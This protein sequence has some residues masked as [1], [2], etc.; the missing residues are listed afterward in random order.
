M[1]RLLFLVAAALALWVS[2]GTAQVIQ[3]DQSA[4]LYSTNYQ[5]GVNYRSIRGVPISN[6]ANV[7]PGSDGRE[8]IPNSA[9]TNQFQGFV[10]YGAVVRPVTSTNLVGTSSFAQNASNIG[11]PRATNS[12]G[13]VLIVLRSAQVGAQYFSRQV[14]FFY[15]AVIPPPT[16][17]VDGN[18]LA[19]AKPEDYWVAEPYTTNGHTNAPYYWS[20]HAGAV[21]AVQPGPI[22]VSWKKAQPS[23]TVPS[24]YPNTNRYYFDS[25]LY[26]TFSNATYIV[27]GS[28]VKPPRK[29]YWTEGVFRATGKPVAVPTARVGA[30]QIVYNT[31][32]FPQRVTNEFVATGQS[33]VVDNVTNRV[34]E[35]RTLWYDTQQ[36]QIYAYNREGR[37]FLEL[38]GDSLGGNVRRHLGY[39]I[40]DVYQ[41]PTPL[42]IVAEL[43]ELI[44]P[45]VDGTPDD[46]LN[47]EL[48]LVGAAQSFLYSHPIQGSDR[49]DRYAAE[50]TVNLNDVLVHWTEAGIEGLRWPSIYGRYKLVWPANIAKYSHYVRP[51]VSTE[52]EARLT[53]VPLPAENVPAIQ[54]QDALDQP[55]AKLT[56]S[57]KFYTFLATN[58][59][60]HRTLLRLTAG[61]NVAFERVFSW[62]DVNL[63][64]TNFNRTLATNLTAVSDFY[65]TGV[66]YP[67]TPAYL[68]GR[69]RGVNGDW[70]LY[71]RDTAGT[72]SGSIVSWAMQVVTTNADSGTL[73][74][75]EVQN[76]SGI[77]I[78]DNANANPYPSPLTITG[79]TDAVV[80]IRVKLNGVTHT[81]PKDIDILLVS[82]AGKVCSIMSAAGGGNPG[83]I[84]VNLILDDAASTLLP[85]TQITSGTFKPTHY[86]ADEA[87]PPGATGSI[88]TS[89]AALLEAVPAPPTPTPWPSGPTAPG[90]VNRIA[91]VGERIEASGIGEQPLAGYILQSKGTSFHP[92]AYK[93]PFVSGF[94][95][96]GR[97]AIIPVNAIPGANNLDIWWFRVNSTDEVKN[98]ANGF[99]PI[100]WPEV[101][102][103]YTLAWPA[104]P[105]E[106]V[107]AS[108]DGSGAMDSLLQRGTIY[109]Q[110]DPT[111]PGFNPNEEH[112]IMLGGTAY[113][114]RDDLNLTG[115][116]VPAVLSG[117][118]A[119]YSSDPFVLLD[120]TGAD[121]RPALQAFKVLREKPS[122][123]IVFDYI[124]EAGKQLQP[125]MPLSFLP[126]PVDGVGANAVN[127]NTEPSG[128]AGDLPVGWTPVQD[129]GSYANYK[130]FT[131]KDR[132]DSF[133]VMRGP[134]A[135]LPALQ[136]GTYSVVSNAFFT[137]L[138]AATAVVG[139]PFTNVFHTSRRTESLVLSL[140]SPTALPEGLQIIGVRLV[141]VPNSAG[142]NFYTFTLTDDGVSVTN[143]LSLNIKTNGSV[144]AQGPLTIT[145]YNKYAFNNAVYVD[146][147]PVLAAPAETN[148]CFTM[149]F[150]YKTQRGFAWP[151]LQNSP[152]EGSIV[153]YL[154]PVGSAA[155]PAASSTP[156]LDIV[157]RPVWPSITPTMMFGQSLTGTAD[158][159]L[160][161][162][163]GQTSVQV[164]YQQSIAKDI[165][166]AKPAVVLHDPTAP[167]YFA[168]KDNSSAGLAQIPDGV[169]QEVYQGKTYF[170]NLPPHL[171]QRFYFDPDRGAKGSLVFKGEYKDEVLGEKY[172]LLNVLRGSSLARGDDLA[173]VLNLC[174][175]APAD[176]KA[177]WDAAITNGMVATVLTKY[178][179]PAVPGQ[180][181]DDP[182]LTRTVGIGNLI[183]V[184]DSQTAVDSYA[185]TA[186]GPGQ[187]YVT[188]ITANSGNP[189]QT[190]TGDKVSVFVVKV[191][192]KLFP[193]EIKIVPSANPLSEVSSFQHTPDLAGRFDEYEYEWKINPPVDG[194]PPVT[195]ATM[196]R[197][198]PLITGLGLPRYTLGGSGIQALVDNY[199]VLRYR[200]KNTSHPLYNQW[201]E[202]T[203]PPTLAE[204]WIKR[205]LAG[206]NP[207]NQRVTDLYNHTVNTDA[208]ILTSAGKRWEGDV[209]LNLKSINNYGLIEIYETVL[210]S[211]E[212]LSIN[213]GINFGPANDALLL[214]AGY[215][216][217]LYMLVG[218]EA[219]AD[220]ANP[221][222]GIGTKDSTYG[223][224]A[225][226]LFA[227]KGQVPTLLD[228]ELALLRGRDDVAQPGVTTTPVYN[229][230]VWNY[231]RG[232]DAGEVIYALNYNILDQN[233]DGKVNAADAA[234][235]YPQGHGD[236]YGHYLT[237]L[238][239]YYGLL[240]NPKFDWVP[241]AEAVTILGKAVSVDY[242]D[243]RKFATAAAAVARTGRQVFDLTWRKDYVPGKDLGWARF[244]TNRV[245]S[246]VMVSGTVT[247]NV[248]REW[249]A[250]QWAS[251][252][253]QGAFLSWVV[254][255]A[256]LP[257]VDPDPTHE[258]I[259]KID[260]TTVPELKELVLTAADLQT[261][262]DNAEGRL[263]P[264]GLSEGSLAFDI[265]PNLVVGT[266]PETHF[267]QIYSRAKTTLNNAVAAFDDAKDVTRLMRSEQD[268]L[269]DVQAAVNQQELAYMNALIE[270]YGTPYTDDIG[271]G[272]TNPDPDYAGP[273]LKHYMYVETPERNFGNNFSFAA[274]TYRVD[275]QQLPDAWTNTIYAD[276]SFY[277]TNNGS[278]NYRTNTIEYSIGDYGMFS[279]PATWSGRRK[280]PGK[281]QQG[282]SDYIAAQSKLRSAL[283]DAKQAKLDL[284]KALNVFNVFN[285]VPI[286]A[287][288]IAAQ[289]VQYEVEELN[290]HLAI[291]E[292]FQDSIVTALQD[293]RQSIVDSIPKE[294]I[295][296]L[297]NGGDLAFPARIAAWAVGIGLEA[298]TLAAGDIY[299]TVTSNSLLEKQKTLRDYANTNAQLQDDLDTKNAVLQ[300]GAQLGAYQSTLA[301]INERARGLEDADRAYRALVAQGDRVQSERE[302]YRQR[303]AA[304]IQGFRTRDA[305]FRIFRN[306]KLERYKT[307]FDL[308]ARYAFLAANAYDYETGLLYT[309][310]GKAFINRIVSS[311]ALG[312][313]K[314]G[315]PQ[316]AGSNTGDPGLSSALAEMKADWD[317][318]KGRLGFN[319]P[320]GYGTTVSLRTENLRILPGTDGNQAWMEALQAARKAN[321]LDDPD[322]RRNCLQIDAGN[323]LPV[324][325]IVL[326]FSTTIADGLNLFGQQLAAGDSAYSSS[327]FATKLYAAGVA[328][329]GYRGM[330]NPVA[331]G[332][333]VNY[334]G[335]TSPP[336]PSSAY[337]D[338]LALAATPYVY[339]I[340]VGEDSMR[341]PPLG[342][343]SAI[344]TWTVNDVSIPLPFNIG[345]SDFS[346]KNLYQS[347]DSLTEPLFSTRKHQAF[348]P[349]S[350]STAFAAD[351]YSGDSLQ[352]SQFTN[353]RL[354][355]R[356]VWNSKWKLVIPGKTLL[357]DPNEGLGRLIQTLTDVKLHFV[358]YSYSGN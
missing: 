161:D 323:G 134:H 264:M 277:N 203:T 92:D 33:F 340:P 332:S 149:R 205:V 350:T 95:L 105:R 343:T 267:E 123:G 194:N 127:Y 86:G 176:Q 99:K 193:G 97:G 262:L 131:Y 229:R 181:I 179:N 317:V 289:N 28:A 34:Q 61:D 117:V 138:T 63:K 75:T 104:S 285:A 135:G 88:L 242:L 166:A 206:I 258:G 126:A 220:A 296:G 300:L 248:V 326:E 232:I 254:G 293:T 77:T 355:G 91:Y 137:N 21:F 167:K 329:E 170:P 12:S 190:P 47:S 320:D 10:S 286:T 144:V 40:V 247:N 335:G 334:A 197:Y 142:S 245:S 270:I 253:G 160:P 125:P 217:D 162:V 116:T 6:T 338:P 175:A 353:R 321:V 115:A 151:G 147:P 59:P 256:I 301:A 62:L 121:G 184:T 309:P 281:I 148:N 279:K 274:Q 230:L 129:S 46:T 195:D 49:T 11:L 43:G 154:R 156:S 20:P 346:T 354:I 210:R 311:R 211:G 69:T 223:S 191:T 71:V 120:Y 52:A 307:L 357:N 48:V 239:G 183:E 259:Q 263:T 64:S 124:I 171:A 58:Y 7:P 213:A 111:K 31:N 128:N 313:V 113:A 265:N 155:N 342:D 185:L 251:R 165:V 212:S 42:D 141:G 84:A 180:F 187:G 114:L 25:G 157:Y 68:N 288:N 103:R 198:Q 225:T 314:D 228:E 122:E 66:D 339:L 284:D 241:R 290:T 196:S 257:D 216:N 140:V 222:I 208:N 177:A 106:I 318:L 209:A 102:G 188:L 85:T 199:I 214:A 67:T 305:A 150:Y 276:F 89:L 352:P 139:Q 255:N 136:A 51:L 168:L 344:R 87:L 15:G 39:E 327:S 90:V 243:E 32:T 294:A 24:G 5:R 204:G 53:A 56:E 348:R 356:S 4:V 13:T 244:S 306:E 30:V 81:Y 96:A 308:A 1:K 200:P 82:P 331:N 74:T 261:A 65:L 76:A 80:K 273:D 54:Y 132:K 35:L 349:V 192:G 45:N 272:K 240:M 153:P 174:P 231:T 298:V 268:S 169:R 219:Y 235:L 17:D 189:D 9:Q 266:S 295:F 94:D 50:E 41:Q 336:D 72:D 304:V 73:S 107:L 207:F 283:E 172:L 36:G 143:T 341:S 60:A 246:R 202:W 351:I 186:S 8:P 280:S 358:T 159:G 322:V 101:I 108:N 291:A 14:S 164:L 110:N 333:A 315:E 233:T 221:T 330:N 302:T 112:A 130:Q 22:Q 118:G 215:L 152:A 98:L 287:N 227:F 23:T 201:S 93:D 250:D 278:I 325:G 292:K 78:L 297:A 44:T 29:I 163:R 347:A 275:V 70:K 337:L 282:I 182:S 249:G 173:T 224:I 178:E 57:S 16:T 27:S 146:R 312:V 319:N 271:P 119:T 324:P 328:L 133:W 345:A 299:F 55:R 19:N 237:A 145:S 18:L 269:A 3:F 226:S 218:N 238:K 158:G 109:T 260:R 310:T 316:Y 26:Y 83:I 100:Y 252:T 2:A 37:V 236:A 38:L 79:I 234:K 303:V